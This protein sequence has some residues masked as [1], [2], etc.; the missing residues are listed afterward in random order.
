MM[1]ASDDKSNGYEGVAETF[2]QVRDS[3]IGP[4]SVRRWSHAL[5]RGCAILDLACGHGVIAQVLID[6]GFE[7]YGVDASAKMIEEFRRRFPKARAE[8]SAIEESEFFGRTFDGVFAWGLMFLLPPDVQIYVI[9]KMARAL[10][11]GGKLLFT[12]PAQICSWKDALTGR[13]SV[14]LGGERYRQLLRKEGLVLDGEESDE[15]GN[16]YYLASKPHKPDWND[17]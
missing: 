1:A 11:P 6:D 12:A 15:G 13:E 14:S 5:P 17:L 2:M 10:N 7:V 9:P 16:H 3:W 8:R 4:N